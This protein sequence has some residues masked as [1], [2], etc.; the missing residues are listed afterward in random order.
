MSSSC[1]V[2]VCKV[3]ES[4]INNYVCK[5][6]KVEEIKVKHNDI[7][8]VLFMFVL[9]PSKEGIQNVTRLG[10]MCNCDKNSKCFI[11]ASF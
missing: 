5:W 11:T 8:F 3:S 6:E 4:K 2:D 9:M 10:L 1:K 7:K